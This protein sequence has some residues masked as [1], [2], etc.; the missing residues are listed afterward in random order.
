AFTASASEPVGPE[1]DVADLAALRPL[2]LV[3]RDLPGIQCLDRAVLAPDARDGERLAVAG[4]E[5]SE[6][7]AVRQRDQL[8]ADTA[9]RPHRNLVEREDEQPRIGRKRGG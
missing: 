1:A 3:L 6:R 2:A 7:N 9:V 5:R 4:R 8:H